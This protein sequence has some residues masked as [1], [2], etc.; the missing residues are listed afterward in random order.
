MAYFSKKLRGNR[1]QRP[2]GSYHKTGQL[3][4]HISDQE[5]YGIVA[6]LY[7]FRIWLQTGVKIKCRTDHKSLES[8]VKEDFDRMGGPVG[9]RSHWHQL[10]ARFPLEVVYIKGEGNGAAD[11]LSRWAYPA[12]LAEPRHQPAWERCRPSGLGCIGA[13]NCAVGQSSTGT[14]GPYGRPGLPPYPLTTSHMEHPG[15]RMVETP[16]P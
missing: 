3:N 8:W 7:K 14:V 11:V 12:Y 1:T 2:D 15:W 13:G 5:M 4:W 10:L 9:R 16:G 6:T